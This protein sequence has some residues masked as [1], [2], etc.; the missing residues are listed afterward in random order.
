M[1]KAVF[2]GTTALAIAGSSLV[3]AQSRQ[4]GSDDAQR[5]RP[6]A[7]DMSLMLDARIVGL[8]TALKL[9]PEQEKSWPAFE[10]A[11]RDIAKARQARML[12]R[13]DQP[14]ADPQTMDLVDRLQRRAT[15][16]TTAAANLTRLADTAKPLYQSLDD[17][18]KHRFAFLLRTFGPGRMAMEHHE[19]GDRDHGDRDGDHD[20]GDRRGPP[21]R[22]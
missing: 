9:T 10:A 6:S 20:R 2:A 18:Q 16:M 7:E 4:S 17:A 1:W 12:A 19:H 22:Q 8:K 15:A 11:I 13:R 21:G 14:P 5:W 3:Y